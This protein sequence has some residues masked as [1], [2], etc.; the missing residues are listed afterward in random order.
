MPDVA[1]SEDILLRPGDNS[2]PYE[3]YAPA[4]SVAGGNDGALP[5]GYSIVSVDVKAY[6]ASRVEKSELIDSFTVNNNVIV[7]NLNYPAVAGVGKYLLRF[8]CTLN[9]GK[10]IT[11]LADRVRAEGY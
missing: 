2:V 3:F 7:V 9:T 10:V 4:A 6:N 1:E 11:F 8:I 5:Y